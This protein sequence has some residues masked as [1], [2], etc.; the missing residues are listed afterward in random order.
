MSF[1]RAARTEGTRHES[2]RGQRP[3]ATQE[4]PV[5]GWRDSQHPLHRC[6]GKVAHG[7]HLS[8]FCHGSSRRER[9]GFQSPSVF[10]SRSRAIPVLS[11]R[12]TFALSFVRFYTS[13]AVHREGGPDRNFLSPESTCQEYLTRP[14]ARPPLGCSCAW[15]SESATARGRFLLACFA[16]SGMGELA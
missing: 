6:N 16:R 9:G 14:A 3:S 2:L 11:F 12:G 1:R 13:D 15:R 7:E 5:V 10:T 8:I 4:S